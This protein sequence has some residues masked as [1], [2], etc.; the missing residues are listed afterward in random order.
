LL[1]FSSVRLPFSL[2][3]ELFAILGKHAK[4]PL[5]FAS[6]NFATFSHLVASSKN[7]GDTYIA[8]PRYVTE[9]TPPLYSIARS[10]QEN[11]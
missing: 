9:S 5:F 4:Q 7:L 10:R 1:P 11:F 6:P 3:N 2:E 8:T